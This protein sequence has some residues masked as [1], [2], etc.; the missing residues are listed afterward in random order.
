MA[1]S[2][3]VLNNRESINI[4]GR[5]VLTLAKSTY[6]TRWIRNATLRENV[7]FGKVMNYDRYSSVLRD[8]ALERDLEILQG[9]DLAE[10]GERGINL[11][12]GQ[13]ARVGLARAV[14]QDTDVV[15]L[16]DVLSAVD[17][18]VGKHL[19]DKCLLG[20]L[21]G[22]TRILVTHSLQVRLR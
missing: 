14:Y 10:I 3:I 20:A 15:L 19:F 13:K 16:D 5:A 1:L 2:R 12:G 21:K 4:Q 18:H 9:G 7:L 6:R 11:S 17:T 22:K 8:C